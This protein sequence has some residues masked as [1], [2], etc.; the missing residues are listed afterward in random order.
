MCQ[1]RSCLSFILWAASQERRGA[2]P[3]PAAGPACLCPRVFLPV[4]PGCL[5]FFVGSAAPPPHQSQAVAKDRCVAPL[6]D[7]VCRDR[8]KRRRDTRQS[9]G[10]AVGSSRTLCHSS[11]EGGEACACSSLLGGGGLLAA[12]GEREEWGRQAVPRGL[13][14]ETESKDGPSWGG[15]LKAMFEKS[16]LNKPAHTRKFRSTWAAA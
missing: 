11:K 12:G 1:P 7:Q 15:M 16:I 13:G 14:L 10:L 5:S 6:Q 2:E 3:S 8:G 4:Q 9:T